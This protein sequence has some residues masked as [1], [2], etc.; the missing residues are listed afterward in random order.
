MAEPSSTAVVSSL[1]PMLYRLIST[2]VS[3]QIFKGAPLPLFTWGGVALVFGGS[4]GYM[5]AP[6]TTSPQRKIKRT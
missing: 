2:I 3:T 6:Q 4:I 1:V 5:L